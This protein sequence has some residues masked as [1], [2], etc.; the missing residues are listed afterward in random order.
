MATQA[1][2]CSGSDCRSS[3]LKKAEVDHEVLIHSCLKLPKD[4]FYGRK[5][6]MSMLMG[7]LQSA[8]MLGDQ[9]LMA[10]IV[11]YPGTG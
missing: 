4:L 10:L 8:T 11:G 1:N 9:P 6:Q 5:V 7:L 2:R 3:W